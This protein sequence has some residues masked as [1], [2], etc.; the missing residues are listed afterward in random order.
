MAHRAL[1]YF[2]SN[3]LSLAWFFVAV[4][5]AFPAYSQKRPGEVVTVKSISIKGDVKPGVDVTAVIQFAVDEGFHTQANLPSEPN[6]IPAVL[7]FEPVVG[8]VV[9]P[10]KYPAGKEEKVEGLP[11]PM[12]VY[13]GTF[14]I[15]VPI[16]ISAG[17]TLPLSLPGLLSYQ[18]CK[19]STCFAPRKL[20]LAIAIGPKS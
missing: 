6:F 19:G 1:G 10:P 3:S 11:K 4:L 16:K 13:E 14:E 15:L 17:A 18:A 5:F 12:K 8:L 9:S 7:K 2:M 20:K